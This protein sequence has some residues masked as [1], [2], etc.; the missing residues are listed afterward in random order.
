MTSPYH[1]LM[2]VVMDRLRTSNFI[3]GP[4]SIQ[5]IMEEDEPVADRPSECDS[6]ADRINSALGRAG[7]VIVIYLESVIRGQ[8]FE[9][10]ADLRVQLVENT[11]YNRD[12]LGTQKACWSVLSAVKDCLDGY[13]SAEHMEWTPLRWEEFLSIDKGVILIREARFSSR[14]MVPYQFNP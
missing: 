4:P 11:E 9:D 14:S 6:I 3:V 8:V 2:R 1:T 5:V 12:Q 10:I 13:S 7:I